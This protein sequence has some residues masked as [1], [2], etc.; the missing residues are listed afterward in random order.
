MLKMTYEPDSHVG[1]DL[2]VSTSSSVQLSTNV[3][4]DNLAQ[5]SFIGGVN[6]LIIRVDGKLYSDQTS[7]KFSTCALN[8]PC[9]L[10]TLA[11]PASNLV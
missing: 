11:R 9:H 7:L 4:A 5:S 10:P 2:V 8:S 6:V 3:F 1:C